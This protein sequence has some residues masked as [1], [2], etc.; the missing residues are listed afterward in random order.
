VTAT[1]AIGRSVEKRC[2]GAVRPDSP[3]AWPFRLAV[4]ATTTGSAVC[5]EK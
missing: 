3:I 4:K 1:V 2:S 5:R